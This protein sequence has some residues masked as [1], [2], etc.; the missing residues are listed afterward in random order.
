MMSISE[1][2][3]NVF[4]LEKFREFYTEV[5]S[6]KNEILSGAKP[7]AEMEDEASG[8][9]YPVHKKLMR[10]LEEQ[11]YDARRQGGEYGIQFY[12]EA[13]YVMAALADDIFLNLNW[14][15]REEW[16][17]DLLEFDL[18]GTYVAGELLFQKTEELLKER[19]PADKDMAAIYLLALSLGFKGKF[20]DQNDGGKLDLYRGQLFSFIF[21]KKPEF[22]KDTAQRLFP[23]AYSY[24]VT[25][26]EDK[27]LPYFSDWVW[28]VIGLALL[29]LVVSSGIWIYFTD[30]LFKDVEELIANFTRTG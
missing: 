16:K 29:F 21:R 28:L 24:T 4:L 10:V 7:S 12:K 23:T 8:Y 27:K 22:L 26:G 2:I 9:A 15:G 17:A 30:S 5:I 13:Q 14:K 25:Q 11:V 20:R 19:N 18:F 1:E 6:Q 3:E